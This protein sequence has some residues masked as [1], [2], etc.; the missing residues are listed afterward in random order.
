[1]LVNSIDADGTREGFD[2]ELLDSVREISP[3]PIIASGGAGRVEHFV[4][5]ARSGADAILAASVF[6]DGLFSIKDVKAAL[7]S[8]DFLV[9]I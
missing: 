6:H 5:A 9:R 7:N 1:M 4:E 8:A 2:I 3:V